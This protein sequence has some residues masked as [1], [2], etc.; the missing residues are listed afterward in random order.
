MLM[1]Y[2]LH[3]KGILQYTI[4]IVALLFGKQFVRYVVV[5]KKGIGRY[6]DWHAVKKFKKNSGTLVEIWA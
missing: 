5:A 6:N 4:C 1:I 2:I 3:T